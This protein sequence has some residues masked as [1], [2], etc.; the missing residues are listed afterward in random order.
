M[1]I[2]LFWFHRGGLRESLDTIT[3]V[4]NI[5]ELKSAIE[6]K[7]GAIKDIKEE[8]GTLDERIGTY[9]YWILVK[10]EVLGEEWYPIGTCTV[11]I[12]KLKE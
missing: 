5:Q 3:P 11:S 6:D 10:Y 1:N 12:T 2:G 8:G 7:Q 4:S 9:R